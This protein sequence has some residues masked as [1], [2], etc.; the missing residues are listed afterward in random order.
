MVLQRWLK[1]PGDQFRPREPICELL[2]DG[3]PETIVYPGPDPVCGIYW[4]YVDEGQE[5]GPWGQLLEYSDVGATT[6]G[7]PVGTRPGP[8]SPPKVQRRDRY[9]RVFLNYRRN[10]S[11][12]YAGRLHETLVREF[13]PD[14]VFMDLFS[15]RPGE[16]FPSSIQQA[17]ARCSVMVC[18]IGTMWLSV[19]DPWGRR[20]LDNP[21]DYVRREITAAQDRGIT[22]IPI[23]LPGASIPE[24]SGLPDEMRGIEQLQ[25]LE[26]S[27]RH[28][29]AGIADLLNT[30][31][32]AL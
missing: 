9:P 15:I 29:D 31:R 11:E 24:A 23:I 21:Y 4:H 1:R 18:I 3:V 20:R 5:V 30:L 10:D 28:W 26:L 14:D 6:V 7:V 8:K 17:A 19:V 32:E 16:P 12:A 25:A 2:I 27:A 22:L 13:G